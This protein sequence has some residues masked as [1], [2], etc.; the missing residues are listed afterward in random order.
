MTRLSKYFMNILPRE[1]HKSIKAEIALYSFV[2]RSHI[3]IFKSNKMS[4]LEIFTSIE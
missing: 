4:K 1:H 2:Y 3:I